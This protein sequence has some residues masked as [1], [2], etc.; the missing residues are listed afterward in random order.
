MVHADHL[1][2]PVRLTD[3]TRA[4]VWSAAYDPFG[5]PWQVT[6]TVEQNLRFPG[7]YFLIETGLAYN[8][9][10]F[11]DPATG[12]YTQPDPLRFVDGSSVYGYA[13]SSPLSLIDALGLSSGSG[14]GLPRSTPPNSGGGQTCFEDC[15][16]E[17]KVCAALCRTARSD[18]NMP[19]IWA[20]DYERC[21]RGC[22]SAKCGGNKV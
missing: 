4:T 13:Q 1:G 12:R 14:D 5:Q 9:H 16:A 15:E 10:R 21:M 20:G 22:I 3:A 6:G 8:W 17:R 7:Q 11:Y 19:N 2:R 18:P